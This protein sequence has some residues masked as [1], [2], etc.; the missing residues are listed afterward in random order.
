MPKPDVKEKVLSAARNLAAQIEAHAAKALPYEIGVMIDDDD[1]KQAGWKF[2]EHELTGT[3]IRIEIGPRDL[4]KNQVVMTRRD[5][6]VKEFV[7]LEGVAAKVSDDLLKMQSELLEKARAFREAN[8]RKVSTY[9]EFK[10]QIE[11]GGFFI[12]SWNGSREVEAKV[13]EE[14]KATIRCLP[15][16]SNYETIASNEPCMVTGEKSE[17]NRVAIFARAY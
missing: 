2:H 3:P 1:T 5:L 13:K 7:N 4:D 16:D 14:T 9:E 10:K 11:E 6:G 8:T 15:L 17:K 12:A